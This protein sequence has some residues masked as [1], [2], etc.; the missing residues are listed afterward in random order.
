MSV[1]VL[2]EQILCHWEALQRVAQDKP[3][4]GPNGRANAVLSWVIKIKK[5]EGP[6]NE[7]NPKI[8]RTLEIK[9]P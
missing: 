6:N 8:R 7:D 9:Q 3:I 5:E 1:S 4:K 2:T